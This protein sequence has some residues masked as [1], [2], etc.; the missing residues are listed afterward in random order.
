MLTRHSL[1]FLAA[2]L[3]FWTAPPL[4]GQT[5]TQYHYIFPVV[6]EMEVEAGRP[7][8]IPIFL[9]NST[10]S[11]VT[12]NVALSG[13]PGF[14]LDSLSQVI[15]V[16][17]NMMDVALVHFVGTAQGA[18][19]TLL[20]VTDGT[21]TDSL[22]LTVNVLPPPGPFVLLPPFHD[23][24]TDINAP[25]QIPV[26]VQN[27]T[28]GALSLSVSL[29]GDNTFSYT[30][31]QNLSV[32]SNGA[33]TL[34]VDF[35]SASEG[36]FQAVLRV[37]DGS[38]TDSV[39]IHVLAAQLPH[40][41]IV[42]FEDEFEAMT[43]VPTPIPVFLQ[44]RAASPV[45]LSLQLTG[46]PEFSL[47]STSTQ[48]TVDQS[49]I[50]QISFLSTA[51]GT[52]QTLLTVTDGSTTDSLQLTV[53]VHP[54]PGNFM[55]M[56]QVS[57]YRV[58]EN[59][60]VTADLHLQN[61]TSGSLSLTVTLTGDSQFSYGGG[62]P[63]S[64]PAQDFASLPI[65]FSGAA[66]GMYSTMVTVSDGT[67]SDSAFVNVI[68]GHP[69]GGGQD[70]TLQY[71][72]QDMFFPFEAAPG[73]SVSKDL[74]ITN[75][76]GAE[77]TVQL[78]MFSDS[79]FTISSRSVTIDSA[80]TETVQVT[81]DNSHGGFGDGMLVLE[82]P[83]QTEHL[84]LAGFT[85]P[86]T[87]YD[88]L[89]VM[90]AL[91]FGMVD[92]SMQVC[93]DV[94]LENT[95]QADISISNI[96]LSGFS[97]DF[98]LPNSSGF[99][100]GAGKTE[101]I[102]VC[103]RPTVLNQ[104]ENEVLTF[105]F[106]NPASTPRQQTATVDLTGRAATGIKPWID[107]CGIVGWYVNTISAPIGGTADVS[108]EL[109]NISNQA[110]TLSSATWEEG[111]NQGIYTLLTQL[112]ITIAPY[113]PSV[114]NSGKEVVTV[115]YAPTA[116][117]STVGVE[118]MALLRF[119]DTGS[120]LP[121]EFYLTL[122]GI[123]IQ[124]SPNAGN[125]VMF[126]KDGRIPVVDLGSGEISSLQ[127]LQLEN[128]LTVPVTIS[129][130]AISS[131]ERYVLE[132]EPAYPILLQ[133]GETLGVKLRTKDVATNPRTD[134]LTMN[135]SHEHLNS[136]INLLSGSSVTGIGDAPQAPARFDVTAAPNPST[137]PVTLTLSSPL[138]SGRVRIVDMVGR[139][140]AEF[141][142]DAQTIQWNGITASG[143]PAESGVYHVLVSG[144]T[145]A[146]APVSASR[147]IVLSR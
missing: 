65:T 98:S 80:G 28:G 103:F 49:D 128:N 118:D 36:H 64:V 73:A 133:P 137:G 123:P 135:G 68:V 92:T 24:M 47:D 75:I 54:G 87:D 48:I 120:S 11:A 58:P 140:V 37:S 125:I 146:G 8:D 139:I 61:L 21:V 41:W 102:T 3:L 46:A 127:T 145:Q 105:T 122:V 18:H 74:T 89:L 56:P 114:P 53:R 86:W 67:E 110:I 82:S 59:Q 63:L 14:A 142:G 117:S 27:I 111:N 13:D 70:F 109:L 42:P 147:R 81:F 129:G 12:L 88:G 97:T 115:R 79:S 95:T 138:Q 83:Q 44:N 50:A 131:S 33:Q 20:T 19:S 107:S 93:L 119:E 31:P 77:L 52:Y 69:H 5:G 35:L 55:I 76:S 40:T 34:A 57:D 91:D 112:P 62:T 66:Q 72:G 143:V 78:S 100:V 32:P 99:T 94:M 90:N 17:P 7:V 15:Q 130:L 29:S 116:Q 84:F 38:Y 132:N 43:G 121:V 104:V 141:R 124:P 71:D 4:T 22:T 2:F 39:M 6:T 134:V 136:R 30:G 96:A 60:P 1:S 85:R 45:T 144:S 101:G 23:L 51:T 9:E 126:P 108:V 25:M 16:T 26:M 10:S 113:N 106:D